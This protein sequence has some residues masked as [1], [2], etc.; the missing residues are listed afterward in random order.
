MPN[1]I[2]HDRCLPPETLRQFLAN[3]LSQELESSVLA[4]LETCPKCQEL[5]D[6]VAR[7]DQFREVRSKIAR[8]EHDGVAGLTELRNELYALA[9]TVSR[10]GE[11]D[12]QTQ[13]YSP[14]SVA[15]DL[16]RTFGGY[17]LLEEIA[18]GGMGVVYRARQTRLDRIVAVKMILAG[19]FA[20]AD[21]IRRF[22]TEAQAAAN[23]D[24][25]HIV[26]IYEVGEYEGRHFYSMGY[27]EG[28]SLAKLLAHGPL[29]PRE[30]AELMC[31]IAEAVQYAHNKG[32]IH[33]DLKP[34]NVLME[35]GDS[36]PLL[37]IWSD[38]PKAVTSPR[39]PK[40]TDFGLAKRVERDSELTSTGQV[41]GTP[42]YMPPEQARGEATIGPPADIYSLG[43]I[44]YCLLT[45]RPPFQTASVMET[46]KQVLE[47]DPLPPRQFNPDIPRDLETIT[48]KCLEK[49]P[50]RRYRTAQDLA[51]ELDCYL[52]HRPILARPISRPE[53][54]WRWCRRNP[55]V[56]ISSI[57]AALLLLII[58]SGATVAYFR[59]VRLSRDLQLAN[60]A[61]RN[62]TIEANQKRAEAEAARAEET[63]ARIRAEE[64]V[65]YL[66]AAF[67]S[68]DPE[69]DGRTIAM[70]DVLDRAVED[71]QGRFDDQPETKATLLDAIGRSYVGLGLLNDP[72]PLFEQA[73]E[74]RAAKFG[75]EHPD[76]LTSM[77]NLA[78][79]Y[80]AA[81][82]LAD[83]ASLHE[84]TLKLRKA[85]LGP[86]HRDTLAS[87][88]N[89]AG[90]WQS[91]G[92]LADA[93]SLYEQTLE[94][95]R[96]RLG[97]EHEDT[98][99]SMNNLAVAYQAAG[100][101]S[102]ALPLFEQ[103]LKIEGGPC[104]P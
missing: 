8:L 98:L 102:E 82:R 93:I 60:Q 23:L 55:A 5:C 13:A 14:T 22:M 84:Q 49:T 4:H 29:P 21:G 1:T 74:L 66:V 12:T 70:A 94:S 92:R 97:P 45:G 72:I 86:E 3:E 103:A 57:T 2:P 26:P 36:S 50:D 68:P 87:M 10:P 101:W 18:R 89:L 25:P 96:A 83:A 31:Q 46:L 91:V 35:C 58:A 44:L 76:T 54:A 104:R 39:T 85:G 30:A 11:S 52:H 24:H 43:A 79:A 71:L 56:A 28:Q 78:N 80:R 42:S 64:T 77:N 27:V 90:A 62:A 40:L 34:G 61:E 100:R 6:S 59:E 67:R 32:V 9:D 99:K 7:S 41:L 81:G 65:S 33:R 88:S 15:D 20:S 38:N 17:E 19:E 95:N 16:P 53:R 37:D 47:S 75:P 69:L 51:D 63:S 73:R 48:L